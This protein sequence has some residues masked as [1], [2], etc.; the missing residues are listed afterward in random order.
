[1]IKFE[2]GEATAIGVGLLVGFGVGALTMAKVADFKPKLDVNVRLRGKVPI[3]LAGQP[4]APTFAPPVQEPVAIFGQ[5]PTGTFGQAP[6]TGPD[7]P[8]TSDPD[9]PLSA[10]VAGAFGVAPEPVSA[11]PGAGNGAA[12]G[13]RF[14]GPM[15]S[16]IFRHPIPVQQM[17]AD[18]PPPVVPGASYTQASVE[19]GATTT[20]AWVERVGLDGSKAPGRPALAAWMDR[21]GASAGSLYQQITNAASAALADVQARGGEAYRAQ[22]EGF[23]ANLT[24]TR[25][26]LDTWY[27]RIK[28]MPQGP[29]REAEAKKW[30]ALVSQYSDLAKGFYQDTQQLLGV[31]PAVLIVGSVAVGLAAVAWAIVAYQHAASLRDQ[32]AL[33]KADLEARVQAAQE[34]YRLQRPTTPTPGMGPGGAIALGIGLS[35]LGLLAYQNRSTLARNFS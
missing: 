11:L 35:A 23:L 17:G 3:S 9:D 2:K 22:V 32:V 27:L 18:T 8:Q 4:D 20:G 16:A 26:D 24:A 30:A 29:E 10:S 7:T 14:G 34:G 25:A 15:L 33:Q 6:P 28:A 5:A 31:A 13:A 12:P 21:L 19:P 1:M